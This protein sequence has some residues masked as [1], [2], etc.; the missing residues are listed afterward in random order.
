MRISPASIC[1]LAS[2]D[3]DAMYGSQ[4]VAAPSLCCL[5]LSVVNCPSFLAR[6]GVHPKGY[7][8]F[9]GAAVLSTFVV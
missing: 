2:Q 7:V 9:G 8:A 1:L 3:G 5:A 6:P 4:I